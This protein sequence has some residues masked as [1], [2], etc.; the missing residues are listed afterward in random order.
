MFPNVQTI[1]SPFFVELGKYKHFILLKPVYFNNKY[2]YFAVH[3]HEFLI[4]VTYNCY[5][6]NV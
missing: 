5:K 6:F 1:L 2:I 3:L 4:L